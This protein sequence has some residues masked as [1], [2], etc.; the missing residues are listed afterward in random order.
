MKLSKYPKLFLAFGKASFKA[1]LEYRMNFVSKIATDIFWYAAQIITFEA[2]YLHTKTL[3][4]WTHEQ[5]RVFLGVLFIV[6]AFYMILFSENLDRLSDKVTKGE[7]DLLLAKPVSSQFMISCQ[8]WVTAIAGNLLIGVGWLV[9]SLAAI[10]DFNW[11]K[12]LWLLILI[13]CGL[14]SL[15]GVRFMISTVTVI[16]TR[17]ENLQYMWYQ[18]Y[19]LG[20]RPDTLYAPWLKYTVLTILP[21]GFIASVPS[22]FLLEEPDFALLALV[23]SVTAFFLWASQAFWKYALKHYA[24]A[25]S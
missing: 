1:D 7:L 18:F 13:P 6:D 19:R 9:W 8:R 20:T 15:Y 12:L 5:T 24:S 16:F 10:P 4:S 25:S 3:G 23:L 11:L 2:L 14:L 21:V 22:H 17:A